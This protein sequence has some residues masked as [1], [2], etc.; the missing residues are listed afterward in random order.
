MK[1]FTQY[2]FK[3]CFNLFSSG[4]PIACML[5]LCNCPTVLGYC[6]AFVKII[7]T[8][9]LIWEV[10]VET[11]LAATLQN[12]QGRIGLGPAWLGTIKVH[13]WA[14]L[15]RKVTF[16][17]KYWVC[18]C[19]FQ[20]SYLLL[21]FYSV[22]K[23]LDDCTYFQFEIFWL[24]HFSSQKLHLDWLTSLWYLGQMSHMCIKHDCVK[25]QCQPVL[26]RHNLES[27]CSSLDFAFSFTGC[28][29]TDNLISPSVSCFPYS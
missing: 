24:F 4:I 14:R 5:C 8:Y 7:F 13:S 23:F 26:R 22:L 11:T 2:Y 20:P 1:I 19:R 21:I 16:H 10:S 29:I 25:R 18:G 12:K 3:F 28:V 27:S 6:V 15:I 9:I 17:W